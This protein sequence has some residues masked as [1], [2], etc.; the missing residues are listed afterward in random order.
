MKEGRIKYEVNA[1]VA[2]NQK[3]IIGYKN[4]LPW[5]LPE[6]LKHFSGLT[7]GHTVL[8][9]RNTFYSLPDKYRPLPNRLNVVFSTTLTKAELA[10][11]EKEVVI[12]NSVESFFEKVKTNEISIKGDKIWVI[13]GQKL[14]SS[15][16]KYWD[17]LELTM[18]NGE[19]EGDTY[20]PEFEDDFELISSKESKNCKFLTYSR[21]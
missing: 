3:R 7:T 6:D 13:G 21:S 19:H 9:G 5:H 17:K 14:Y 4:K 2:M 8:M 16:V 11:S 12:E 15:T 18:V 1:I 10:P 20:F